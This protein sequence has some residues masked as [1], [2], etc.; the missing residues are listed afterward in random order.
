MT[1]RPEAH[2]FTVEYI[3]THTNHSLSLSECKFLPLPN[4]IRS[5]IASK[6]SQGVTVEKI[7]DGR[8]TQRSYYIT[9]I[10]YM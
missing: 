1:V 3:S 6:V 5:D 8:C 7:M 10:A 2:G 4:D 9:P